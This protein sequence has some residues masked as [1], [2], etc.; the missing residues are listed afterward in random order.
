MNEALRKLFTLL[1]FGIVSNAT[2]ATNCQGTPIQVKDIEEGQFLAVEVEG[3]RYGIFKRRLSQARALLDERRLIEG[4]EGS[5]NRTPDWWPKESMPPSSSSWAS[6]KLRSPNRELFVFY[7]AAPV[8]EN[9]VR[10]HVIHYPRHK[11]SSFPEPNFYGEIGPD[12]PGGFIDHC[13]GVGYDY[14]GKPVFSVKSPGHPGFARLSK[15]N[16]IVPEYEIAES[17]EELW[18]CK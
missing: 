14:S 15:L 8:R 1:M 12:W 16:L 6:E 10:C 2:A 9:E 3:V 18:V 4:A 13:S 11:R 5:T 17:G 7:T